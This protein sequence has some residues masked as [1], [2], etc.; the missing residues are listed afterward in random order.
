[1]TKSERDFRSNSNGMSTETENNSE[2]TFGRAKVLIAE[3][4]PM[5]RAAL[6][7]LLT[8]DGYEVY[9][10]ENLRTATSAI[11]QIDRLAVLLVDLEMPEWRSI[12]RH[13]YTTRGLKRPM[14]SSSAWKEI[15]R[16]QKCMTLEHAGFGTVFKSQ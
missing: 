12:I 4:H 10:A 8:Q 6:A 9:Q 2:T 15:T 1:M 11:N 5:A 13:A 7:V 3:K 16:S 14:R